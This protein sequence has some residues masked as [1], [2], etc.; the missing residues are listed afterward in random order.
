MQAGLWWELT[1]EWIWGWR[2]Y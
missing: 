2:R 1:I